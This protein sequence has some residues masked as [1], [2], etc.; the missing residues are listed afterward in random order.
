M[1]AGESLISL[2][3]A[4]EAAQKGPLKAPPFM[5]PPVQ[6]PSGPFGTVGTVPP[7]SPLWPQ[8]AAPSAPVYGY[9]GPGGPN[10]PRWRQMLIIGVGG[11]A[12]M[13][14]GRR[15]HR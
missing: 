15:W 11:L 1:A 3:P 2:V 10:G 5:M 7:F 12:M 6:A 14:L 4:L 8:L 9:G 13:A